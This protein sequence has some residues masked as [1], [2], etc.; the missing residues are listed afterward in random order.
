MAGAT[1]ATDDDLDG[2]SRVS[3]LDGSATKLNRE[4]I[5]WH[6]PCYLQGSGDPHGGP[7]RTTPAGAIR[8]GQYKLIEWF[9]TG[10][11]E[12]YDLSKDLSE[13]TDLSASL[14]EKRDELL[15]DMRKWRETVSA[16]V[17]TTPNP[18]YNPDA[19]KKQGLR[20]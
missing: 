17:P 19:S 9:E 18:L 7:F 16:P 5:Y 2:Q 13:S 6:F 14:P 15:A 3:L 4:A 10:R 8:K 12:L 20:P 11:L 1:A